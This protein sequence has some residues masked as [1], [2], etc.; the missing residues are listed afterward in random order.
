MIHGTGDVSLDPSQIPAFRT[1][2]YDWAWSGLGGLFNHDDLTIANLECPVDRHRRSRAQGV[3]VPVRSAALPA[4]RH[5]GIDVVSQANN[6]ASIKDQRVSWTL[7]KPSEPRGW[8]RSSRGRR[9][10]GAPGREVRD[11]RLDGRRGGDRPDPRPAR[12]GRGSEQA[13]DGRGSRLPART[14]SGAATRPRPRPRLRHDPL[15]RRARGTAEAV[16]GSP[17]PPDDRCGRRRDLRSAPARA[18]ADGDVP[19]SPDLLQPRQ[20]RVASDLGRG[21]GHGG[22]GSHRRA[23]W[24]IHARM[25]PIEIVSDG[26]PVVR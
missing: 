6:H 20:P 26:H 7:S 12:P 10:G 8:P 14:S 23:R 21:I 4:A 19:G 15:G 3:H 1:H 22:R 24:P 2:G 16:P 9:V 17:G 5:A 25:V 11:P 13:G 18:P